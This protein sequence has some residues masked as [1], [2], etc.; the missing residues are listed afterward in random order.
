[1]DCF[2]G[3]Q[4]Q[5]FCNRPKLDLILLSRAVKRGIVTLEGAYDLMRG[6][7]NEQ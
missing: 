4:F 2:F 3:Y 5:D 6:Y 7:F 1:M